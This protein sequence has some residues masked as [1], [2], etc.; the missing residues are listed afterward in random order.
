MFDATYL[1]ALAVLGLVMGGL[2]AFFAMW[3]TTEKRAALS[4]WVHEGEKT[5]WRFC[6]AM[7]YPLSILAVIFATGHWLGTPTAAGLL[8]GFFV[9]GTQT[10][11]EFEQ[12]LER[13]QEKANPV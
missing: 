10:Q 7:V 5:L 1:N 3:Y 8:I 9:G 12:E 13:L 4:L 6:I 11:D 2:I